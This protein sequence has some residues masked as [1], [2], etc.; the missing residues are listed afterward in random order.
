MN[1]IILQKSNFRCRENIYYIM[2][3]IMSTAKAR[4][5]PSDRICEK[6]RHLTNEYS[7]RA[8]FTDLD[9]V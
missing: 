8:D 6:D 1:E 5:A 2:I 7:Y 3:Y 9:A 4:E